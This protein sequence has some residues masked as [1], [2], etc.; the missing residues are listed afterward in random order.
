MTNLL[1]L[2]QAIADINDA[3]N[4]E[5]RF[6]ADSRHNLINGVKL[7]REAVDALERDICSNFDERDRTVS[8]IIGNSPVLTTVIEQAEPQRQITEEPAPAPAKKKS[9]EAA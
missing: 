1:H 7:I 2:S 5:S 4:R 6:S 9:V 3:L 8:R